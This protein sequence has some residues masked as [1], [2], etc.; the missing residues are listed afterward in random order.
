MKEILCRNCNKSFGLYNEKYYGTK[1]LEQI[2][3]RY[4]AL[5]EFYGHE[6]IIKDS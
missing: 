6:I 5:H 2:A 4:G 3:N 1:S